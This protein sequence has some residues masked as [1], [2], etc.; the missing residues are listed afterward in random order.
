MEVWLVDADAI[1][2]HETSGDDDVVVVEDGP[3]TSS[4]PARFPAGALCAKIEDGPPIARGP[5]RLSTGARLGRGFRGGRLVTH[6]HGGGRRYE[7]AC[8]GGMLEHL[9]SLRD[10]HVESVCVLADGDLDDPTASRRAVALVYL[11]TPARLW[12]RGYHPAPKDARTR[13][14]VVAAFGHARCDWA[15]SPDRGHHPH[16]RHQPRA[17]FCGVVGCEIHD[18]SRGGPTGSLRGALE[19]LR[20]CAPTSRPIDRA[21]GG[22]RSSGAPDVH[23]GDLPEMALDA[24]LSRLDPRGCAAFASTC[25]GARQRVDCRAP[26]L[27]L[28]LHPHQEAG[29]AWMRA[30]ERPNGSAS[31]PPL[32]DPRWIGPTRIEPEPDQPSPSEASDRYWVNVLTGEMSTS[33]PPHYADSPGGLLCDEPG[34]G[35]TVTALALVLATRGARPAP[36]DGHRARMDEASGCWYYEGTARLAAAAATNGD[37]TTPSVKIGDGNVGNLDSGHDSPAYTPGSARSQVRRSRRS[38][39]PGVGHFAKIERAA[40]LLD[41]PRARRRK[42]DDAVFDG[43]SPAVAVGA[44][45]AEIEDDKNETVEDD[46]SLPPPG[47]RQATASAAR[48]SRER[49]M[50]QRNV[51]FFQRA[52]AIASH[53]VGKEVAYDA[54]EFVLM[55]AGGSIAAGAPLRLPKFRFN[56]EALKDATWVL[57]S[58]GLQPVAEGERAG[59][60]HLDW[61]P[62]PPKSAEDPFAE[63]IALDTD[64]LEEALSLSRGGARGGAEEAPKIWLSSATLVI[65]PPVLISHWLEQIAFTTGAAED[66]PSVCVVGGAKGKSVAGGANGAANGEGDGEDRWLFG[67]E[68]EA[69][70]SDLGVNHGEDTW[71]GVG[72]ANAGSVRRAQRHDSLSSFH[73]LAP[74][75]LA[76]RWDLVIIPVNRLSYE[77]SRDSPILRVHWQRVV[78][79]EGHQLGGASAIT[80]K[81]SMACALRAHAR[82]VMTG[83][84]TPATL[85][86]AGVGHLHPLLAFLRQAPYASSQQLWMQAIQRPLDGGGAKGGGGGKGK[87]KGKHGKHGKHHGDDDDDHHENDGATAA[88]SAM[89]ARAAARAADEARADAA[90]RL[91]SLLRRVAIRTLKSDI[92]LPPLEREVRSLA[93]TRA[94]ALSYNEIV[95]HVRRSLLLADWAD[96]SHV[97]SL[98]N[99]RQTRLAMEAVQN[100]R[101]AACVTGVYPVHCF[102]PEM[103]ETVED[104]VAA[105]KRRG[106]GHESATARANELRYPLTVAKGRCQRCDVDAFMPLVTPCGHLLCC[107]CVAV[108]GD[109]SGRGVSSAPQ[110]DF[111]HETRA[112]VRCPVCASPFKMQAPDPRLD[113][114]APRQAVPQDLIEIQPSYVQLPWRMSDALEAQGESTKVEYLLAR[115]RELGAAPLERDEALQ[116]DGTDAGEPERLAVW[117]RRGSGPPPKCIVYS[118]FRTHLDVIDLALSG[119]KVNFANIAR[120]GMSRWDKDRALASFRADPDVSVLLLDRAAAEGL[121]LS[122]VQRV[123]VAEP[124]DNASLEQQV[125]SRAHRMG[126][127]GTVRVEVLAMRGTAEETLL[128]V[129]AELA[130]AAHAAAEESRARK[131]REEEDDDWLDE[132]EDDEEEVEEEDREGVIAAAAL[133]EEA[134]QAGVAPAIAAEALSRR[135]VLQTLKLIPAPDLSPA[136]DE[137]GAG[138]GEEET[139]ANTAAN[140][141]ANASYA[142]AA[143]IERAVEPDRSLP[144]PPEGGGRRRAVTFADSTPNDGSDV[145]RGAGGFVAMTPPGASSD[146]RDDC[147]RA[148][149]AEDKGILDGEG[150]SG[151]DDDPTPPPEKGSGGVEPAGET[152]GEREWK[153]RL[154]ALRVYLSAAAAAS[155]GPP[156]STEPSP[157]PP[158]TITLPNGGDTTAAE[159]RGIGES[160][161]AFFDSS[162]GIHSLSAGVPPRLLTSDDDDSTL[163][164]LGVNDRDVVTGTLFMTS[165][166]AAASPPGAAGGPKPNRK[167]AAGNVL[168]GSPSAAGI[169]GVAPRGTEVLDG[170]SPT[171]NIPKRAKKVGTFKGKKNRLGSSDDRLAVGVGGSGQV[172]GDTAGGDVPASR[173]GVPGLPS[174]AAV[175]AIAGGGTGEGLIGRQLTIED[176]DGRVARRTALHAARQAVSTAA[177]L[178]DPGP[179]GGDDDG[180]SQATRMAADLMRAAEASAARG[181]AA[182][183]TIASLQN[184]FQAVVQE[185]AMEAEGNRKV[186]AAVAGSATFQSLADGRLVVR[187][188]AP[189]VAAGRVGHGGERTEIVQDLPAA[190]L[191]LVLRVVAADQSPAARQNLAPAAMAVASPRV[192]WA[193]VR[194]GGVGGGDGI[195][196][197]EALERLAPGAADWASIAVRERR[198]PERYS[199]YVSH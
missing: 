47:F 190:L 86:G 142:A 57:Y 69:D 58:I 80:A 56:G 44:P 126:Q 65:L 155:P 81:L 183:P 185:R 120:I 193:I 133:G 36:P 64:A 7:W 113:N 60:L 88:A 84:P 5:E 15:S 186:S 22:S 52:I 53:N 46:P 89:K 97:E 119:A 191:P 134:V 168:G 74:R 143:A 180:G 28:R 59:K 6:A 75:E 3:S 131:K 108:V 25:V 37:P 100:L 162:L 188:S 151:G 189:D 179:D 83:T 29:L 33:P 8:R 96:P 2:P 116:G 104:L 41:N 19:R 93:F 48:A 91:G 76:N 18:A 71:T 140:V 21:V 176:I 125:V 178:A 107:G 141:T 172:G 92:R 50:T 184:A 32:P 43:G 192:F 17:G 115:L 161:L 121:D 110:E 167:R 144:R 166:A 145:N 94:H 170:P 98:L 38:T 150:S 78:L 139:A 79:D 13:A 124:L 199:E 160:A 105:L 135:R 24:V 114:P 82:W 182:D 68:G 63:P 77:F 148:Q 138:A 177:M 85:K 195:G 169:G 39:T 196:F 45:V 127:R 73:G 149:N 132:E 175:A 152:R 87:D 51:S 109:E 10:T 102:G 123:F 42:L 156:R 30:R 55:N 112:P 146:P 159:L 4:D 101:E 35:K 129:Q 72:G 66:G 1:K 154:R 118:G 153:I 99:P 61:A 106:H 158:H 198:R 34:L 173:G 197:A 9:V 14:A 90:A 157:P 164:S 187:Y 16:R 181:S 171:A 147:N 20:P 26:G 27:K 49:A 111:L 163:R 70:E 23:I 12:T 103:D 117:S 54:C 40:F 130:A 67:I 95:S 128:D 122:F 137:L 165:E 194:H 31:M 62:P 136:D 11:A 174:E